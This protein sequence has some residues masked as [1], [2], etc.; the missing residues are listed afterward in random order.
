MYTC[1]ECKEIKPSCDFYPYKVSVTGRTRRCKE[2]IKSASKKYQLK[3]P[4]KKSEQRR[5]YRERA[6]YL[7][8][9]KA[10]ENPMFSMQRRLRART[11][12]A[13]THKGIRTNTKTMD[14]LGCSIHE[15]KRHLELQFL[16]GMNWENRDKWHID[17]ILPLSGAKNEDDA[18]G[19]CHYTN[20]RPIWARDNFVKSGKREHLI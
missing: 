17:H 16:T 15:L 13:L 9:K 5:N 11:R 12:D 18:L 6:N 8:R 1:T 2:C 14:M 4:E 3:N 19:L 20:L 10:R 7:E